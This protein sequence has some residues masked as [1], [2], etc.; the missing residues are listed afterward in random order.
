MRRRTCSFLLTLIFVF[1]A[2]CPVQAKE[3]QI[4]MYRMFCPASEEHLHT[5]DRNEKNVLSESGWIY[6]GVSW[7]APTE[8]TDPVFRLFYPDNGEHLYTRDANERRVLL[9]RGWNDEG[10]GWYS[11][12]LQ[13]VPVYR[14]FMPGARA[15]ASHHYTTDANERRVLIENGWNDEGIAWYAT[16]AGVAGRIPQPVTRPQPSE[17][18]LPQP[19][20]PAKMWNG[21]RWFLFGDSITWF[22]HAG[23][24]AYPWELKRAYG[25]SFEYRSYGGMRY[26]E[27]IPNSSLYFRNNLNTWLP[28]IPEK[29]TYSDVLIELGANDSS[30]YDAAALDNGFRT[31]IGMIRTAFPNARIHIGIFGKVYIDARWEA[32]K[33]VAAQLESLCRACGCTWIEGNTNV[34]GAKNLAFDEV[35]PSDEGNYLIYQAVRNYIERG[36]C[37]QYTSSLVTNRAFGLVFTEQY[38]AGTYQLRVSGTL[39][40]IRM[41]APVVSLGS[42]MLPVGFRVLEEKVLLYQDDKMGIYTITIVPR[43][44]REGDAGEGWKAD[45]YLSILE[46]S[47]FVSG[48]V[49]GPVD[50]LIRTDA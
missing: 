6:E 12:P 21:P 30:S 28:E 38:S 47:E 35:H 48:F 42:V 24:K 10:I 41:D 44:V 20:E 5:K 29:E 32:Q 22:G 50:F 16:A 46:P 45:V 9:E 14:L 43:I 13:R 34:V 1:L 17:A 18:D 4:A 31:C 15:V 25:E 40:D 3:E 19:Q 26:S 39:R 36:E 23:D 7:Y 27:N 49:T 37:P 2:F 33:Q 8:S 11:D